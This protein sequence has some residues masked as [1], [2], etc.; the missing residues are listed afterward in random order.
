MKAGMEKKSPTPGTTHGKDAPTQGAA[1]APDA[2]AKD[3][4][5]R[6]NPAQK[7][8]HAIAAASHEAA[9]GGQPG[10]SAKAGPAHGAAEPGAPWPRAIR[11]RRS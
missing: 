1:P 9:E 5:A 10:P 8:I 2:S 11:G 7:L 4:K 3:S 6:D